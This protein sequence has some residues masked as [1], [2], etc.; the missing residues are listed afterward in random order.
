MVA[1]DT[2]CQCHLAW[3]LDL[4]VFS[5]PPVWECESVIF[6]PPSIKLSFHKNGNDLKTILTTLPNFPDQSL[7]KVSFPGS[8]FPL[9]SSK[10]AK[11]YASWNQQCIPTLWVFIV[12]LDKKGRQSQEISLSWASS[13]P[14]W[15]YFLPVCMRQISLLWASRDHQL[16]GGAA[17][18]LLLQPL[19]RYLWQCS[20]YKEI[21]IF[22]YSLVIVIIIITGNSYNTF[23]VAASELVFP[24]ISVIKDQ[25]LY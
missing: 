23:Y 1:F 10:E 18:L 22:A 6:W 4:C 25:I 24:K 19:Q 12:G 14:R 3:D 8:Q 9:L 17:S 11:T 16:T 20:I 15:K 7:D 13:S 2:G 21:W 5:C